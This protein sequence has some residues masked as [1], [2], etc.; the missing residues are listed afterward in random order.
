MLNQI[1]PIIVKIDDDESPIKI[2]DSRAPFNEQ[3]HQKERQ[4]TQTVEKIN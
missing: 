3:I 1:E 2:E 4:K